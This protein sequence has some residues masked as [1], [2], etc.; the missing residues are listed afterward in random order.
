MFV[1]FFLTDEDLAFS[2]AHVFLSRSP[3]KNFLSRT[4]PIF[5]ITLSARLLDLC[6][7]LPRSKPPLYPQRC[8][9]KK[10]KI[11][12]KIFAQAQS[13]SSL[14]FG[15][16]N[17]KRSPCGGVYIYLQLSH[18]YIIS[19]YARALATI[20]PYFRY[21]HGLIITKGIINGAYQIVTTCEV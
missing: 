9:E 17:V 11:H 16:I 4:F 14:S 19:I 1:F 2:A 13:V 7:S 3:I 15:L 10:G 21:A 5:L 20:I 6:K 8:E 12:Y 18:H